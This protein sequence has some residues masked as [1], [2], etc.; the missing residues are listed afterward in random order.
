MDTELLSATNTTKSGSFIA[1]TGADV[2]FRRGEEILGLPV[3]QGKTWNVEVTISPADAKA[4]LLAMPPQ[5]M[6]SPT[7]VRYFAELIVAGRFRVTHQGLAFDK[8]GKLLDGMHRLTACVQADRAISVQVTFNLDRDLFDAMDRGRV[9]NHADDLVTGTLTSDRKYAEIMAAAAKNIWQIERGLVP[10]NPP[11]KYEFQ[12]K[13]LREIVA[14]HEFIY[15]AISYVYK[16]QSSWRGIGMGVAATFYTLFHAIN[17]QKAD[18][19]IEQ[20]ALGENL[21]YGDPAYAFREYRRHAG[22]AHG[23]ANRSAIMITLVRAWNAFVEGRTLTRV[24][25][26]MP[27][28]EAFPAISKG[29]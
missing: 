27:I 24:S 15:D 29:K 28:G 26:S 11:P 23:R 22:S 16:H 2:V 5:R 25:S 9:R 21:K 12:M 7:N 13:E 14:R 17:P 10:W 18:V 20:V 8:E 4:I 6:L 19:F 1:D 3:V